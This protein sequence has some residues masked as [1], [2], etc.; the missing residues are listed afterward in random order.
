LL[1]KLFKHVRGKK[2][3]KTAA[4]SGAPS[5]SILHACRELRA[6]LADAAR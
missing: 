1:D 4:S 3:G 2:I 6:E 5:A